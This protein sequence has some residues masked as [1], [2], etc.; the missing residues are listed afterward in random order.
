MEYT[1]YTLL[2]DVGIISGLLLVGKLIRA[3]VRPVQSL[4][5]PSAITAG[6]L[7]LILGPAVLGWLPFSD[8][9]GTYST[10]LIAVVFGA[11]PYSMELSGRVLK[12]ARAMWSFSTGMYVLQWGIAVLFSLIVLSFLFD[13][14]DWFG[15]MLPVG[16][17]G[18]F[19]T[20]AAIGGSLEDSGREAAMTLGFT[21]ATIGTLVA[22]IGGIIMAKWGA[23]KGYT[24]QIG[25]TSELPQEL[26][27][28]LISTIGQRPAIGH[29]T[30]SPSSLE[31]L[32]M[33][34]SVIGMTVLG[35]YGV[36]QGVSAL[37][38]DVSIP[39]FALAFVVGM[40]G[41]GVLDVSNA[42]K[43]VDRDTISAVSGSATDYLVAFGVASIV[44]SIVADFAVPFSILMV[45]GLIY[46]LILFRF[47]SPAM[48]GKQ[49]IERGIFGWGWATASV[50]T[51]IA[52][53]K[54]VDPKMKSKTLEEFGVAYV[55]Y[56]P[57]EIGMTIAVPLLIIAGFAWPYA[58][59][60]TLGGIAVFVIAFILGW[61][62][63]ADEDGG[64]ASGQA[65]AAAA[66]GA[67][68]T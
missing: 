42:K 11:M 1:P 37:F 45:V 32:A 16:W 43:Y 61:T 29:A 68:G 39:L 14:P 60:V 2:I 57:F 38:P 55:G 35:A 23:K 27:T 48:F 7:G 54:I 62:K 33:H 56:S 26:R 19:G 13:A 12:G 31:S 24:S 36:Q 4:L 66:S 40:A 65:G 41:R 44:P 34:V 25:D 10:L 3:Y 20:A 67:D 59:V 50:A 15:L 8:Q 46:C 63:N 53:L 28:G 22:I 5:I 52:L 6:I 58:I 18:G 64:E 47:V 49:W 30:S 9:L 21:S 17:V 51:A